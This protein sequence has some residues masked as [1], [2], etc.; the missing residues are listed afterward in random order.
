MSQQQSGDNRPPSHPGSS[1]SAPQRDT[2]RDRSEESGSNF[3][4]FDFLLDSAMRRSVDPATES[5]NTE[6]GP[7]NAV[8]TVTLSDES[9]ETAPVSEGPAGAD[10]PEPNSSPALGYHPLGIVGTDHSGSIIIT[11][12]YM[13]LDGTEAGGPGR[14]GSLV[15]TLPN[16]AAN[17]QPR[18]IQLFISLATR[19]A[20][21]VLVSNNQRKKG[22]HPETFQKFPVKLSQE[23]QDRT[24]AICFDQYEE[25]VP[26]DSCVTKKRKTNLREPTPTTSTPSTTPNAHGHGDETLESCNIQWKHV[27]VQLPCGH[28]F[29]Q[30]CLAHWLNDNRNCPL[31]RNNIPDEVAERNDVLP[32][33]YLRFGGPG[34]GG[35]QLFDDSS[36]HSGLGTAAP[37]S[38]DVQLDESNDPTPP[39]PQNPPNPG[40]LR[41]ATSVIFHPRRNS[42][43]TERQPSPDQR[44][45]N[46]STAPMI[47]HIFSLFRRNQR[48]E[49][50]RRESG[51]PERGASS[52][53][54][55]GVSS[56]R[57][58]D[59]VE[60]VTTEH[61]LDE[62]AFDP[63]N[64]QDP[65]H[66][67]PREEQN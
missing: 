7:P 59:G 67:T 62:S 34:S 49:Q 20:Y 15:V 58:A 63:E 56:R 24:C 54:A 47:S 26:L 53:F 33:T 41:R 25:V 36:P 64:P 37:S 13:F 11:V 45:R 17:R 6:T 14:T 8:P 32:V 50:E 31:C 66:D 10:Q 4:L 18:A 27:P 43:N 61:G 35:M 57:T 21:L 28:I 9:T 12:N 60:T 30:S 19:M 39:L 16:N 52:I 48:R 23:L 38:Q 1:D 5:L 44:E 51:D 29:G 3:N 46:P 22:I 2:V 55:S 40:L 65:S 42:R